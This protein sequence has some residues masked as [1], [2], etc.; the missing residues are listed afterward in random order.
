MVQGDTMKVNVDRKTNPNLELYRKE[1]LDISYAF[2]KDM[3][4]ELG[5]FLKAVVLFG[6]SARRKRKKESDLDIMVV[7]DDISLNFSAELVEAYRIIVQR[8]IAKNSTRL[9]V[10]SLRF[11]SFWEYVK[12]GDPIAIN[13]LR[14]GVPLIDT[15]FFEPLQILLRRGR[16]RPTDE[17]IWNYYIRA[18]NTLHNAKWHILQATLDLYWAV[19]DAAHAALMQH[20]EVPPSPDHISDL[21]DEKLVKNRLLEK[22]Y[23]TT[24]R[25]FYRLS[26]MITH[27]EITE[28]KGEEFDRYYKHA[29]EFVE[30]M[31]RFI[32]WK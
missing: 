12:N 26:K 11:S 27:S 20:G 29:E 7:V 6:S 3:H 24:M 2:T 18:P 15:G 19:I 1:D 16:I 31:R 9:H 23:T 5:T 32:G 4:K 17:S 30:R 28:I 25:N 22:R 10:T 8:L 14:D 21:L 13:I